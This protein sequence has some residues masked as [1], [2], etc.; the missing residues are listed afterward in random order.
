MAIPREKIRTFLNRLRYQFQEV[1]DVFV[2]EQHLGYPK[3]CRTI[4]KLNNDRTEWIAIH[5]IENRTIKRNEDKDLS[6]RK[7]LIHPM[8]EI[9][10]KYYWILDVIF[11]RKQGIYVGFMLSHGDWHIDLLCRIMPRP[12][13]HHSENGQYYFQNADLRTDNDEFYFCS[14]PAK[15]LF[16]RYMMC[17]NVVPFEPEPNYFYFIC[18]TR[19]DK[20]MKKIP[21]V[22]CG[23][24]SYLLPELIDTTVSYLS[25]STCGIDHLYKER[26]FG[27]DIKSFLTTHAPELI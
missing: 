10:K 23:L 3:K 8:Y 17:V 12:A 11:E 9:M 1:K 20:H 26:K 15:K 2:V 7:K 19:P 21:E 16:D 5:Q 4:L 18:D 24:E 27:T 25:N 14:N 6:I 22:S 13:W